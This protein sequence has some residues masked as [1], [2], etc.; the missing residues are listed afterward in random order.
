MTFDTPDT[1][2]EF[3]PL[4]IDYA[5]VQSKVMLKYDSWHKEILAKFGALLGSEMAAFHTQVSKVTKLTFLIM[6]NFLFQ[7]LYI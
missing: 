1:R 3:G 4:V 2:R 6:L 5:K 7:F